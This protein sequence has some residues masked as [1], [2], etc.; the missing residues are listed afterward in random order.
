MS[1]KLLSLFLAVVMLAL[2][3]PAAVLPAFAA[4][5]EVSE[6]FTTTFSDDDIVAEYKA[7]KAAYTT[8]TTIAFP[9]NWAIGSMSA[10]A[11]DT[12][13]R[14]TNT[15]KNNGEYFNDGSAGWMEGNNGGGFYFS[16]GRLVAGVT[17]VGETTDL[18]GD[19]TKDAND[20]TFKSVDTNS[21]VRYTAPY[22]G[23][24]TIDVT[25]LAFLN[26]W[27]AKFCILVNGEP[28]EEFASA[29]F[30]Y[31]T[32][33]GW[34]VPE[35]W[36]ALDEIV[37]IASFAINEGDKIDFVFRAT[38]VDSTN[39]SRFNYQLIKRLAE[40]WG[41]SVTY[42]DGWQRL[43]NP[44][45]KWTGDANSATVKINNTKG[46]YFFSWFTADGSAKVHSEPLVATDVI[47]V[48][49]Y[50]IEN[51]I[52]E[53]TDTFQEA[54]DK[55]V[56]YMKETYCIQYNNNWSMGAMSPNGVYEPIVYA[57]FSSYVSFMNVGANGKV[58]YWD[59]QYWVTKT[60][61][62]KQMADAFANT[63][64]F[65]GA[66][67]IVA[68]IATPFD[69]TM[70]YKNLASTSAG[71]AVGGNN[72]PLTNAA[73]AFW[74][75]PTDNV[76]KGSYGAYVWTAS[77]SGVASIKVTGVAFAENPTV[78]LPY[79]VMINGKIVKE[80]ANLDTTSATAAADL[81][82]QIAT[83]E[84]PVVEGD[85]V[86][87]II[88]RNGGKAIR[89]D[90][91][92]MVALDTSRVPVSYVRDGVTLASFIAKVGEPLPE[93]SAYP[94]FGAQ[95]CKI[96]GEYVTALPEV[97]EGPMVIEDFFTKSA[98]SI[99]IASK[100]TI[101]VYVK[102]DA[103]AIGAGIIVNNEMMPG[104]K[105][106]DGTYKVEALTV[107]AGKLQTATFSYVAYQEYE[108]G[109][110]INIAKSTVSSKALLQ[111]YATG[112]Y[113]ATTKALASSVLDLAE[114]LRAFIEY[115]QGIGPD[116]D[117]N[118]KSHLKGAYTISGNY[119]SGKYDVYLGTLKQITTG[120]EPKYIANFKDAVFVP[121]STVTAADKVKM[122]YEEG[123]NPASSE[124]KY[125]IKAV[126]LNFEDRIGFAF[127][128]VANGS[129]DIS[130]LRAGGK[131]AI[132]VYDGKSYSYYD[133]F[134]YE[135]SDKNAKAIVVDGVPASRYD[136]DTEFTV[137]ERQDDG[138]YKAVGAT[139][140]YSVKAYAVTTFTFGKADFASYLA[141][142]LF[143]LGVVADEYVAAH[144]VA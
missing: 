99:T 50:L 44:E 92:F 28:V 57:G 54:F 56:A 127:R 138:S 10:A 17:Y 66:N 117:S 76:G 8:G 83:I 106:A 47:K 31:A 72:A 29:D 12:N 69:A 37:D 59:N 137:V 2:A 3:I 114:A 122:G 23:T 112:N 19:G 141:Q 43:Y 100:Y 115:P 116:L 16:N 35:K 40:D 4:D 34:F 110:R 125:A 5:G 81:N 24:V 86:A 90:A 93:L 107:S 58:S 15:A 74:V 53:K 7:N 131:Y 91:D 144:P 33:A 82:E 6:G 26:T 113:D 14:V 128:I 104:V 60:A 136:Y 22:T 78:A 143:R 142:A 48:N 38:E 46:A 75:R 126:T 71:Y 51:G 20:R 111:A 63:T 77:G 42:A 67:E 11:W 55:W 62:D 73:N 13:Y 39:E 124:Y 119:L 68:D 65:I 97:V 132:Q 103:D 79:A 109:Y 96:N 89:F 87:I 139:L 85:Q 105:Q 108:D 88:A 45:D 95:G 18:N 120:E 121:D 61:F 135:G 41:F 134:L 52:V 70:H 101:N 140:T 64:R 94:E 80:W 27:N 84:L 21:V 49:P 98:A 32:G 30:D 102:A 9:E 129:N 123:V 130:E 133:A 25:K 1:K 118:V 36:N